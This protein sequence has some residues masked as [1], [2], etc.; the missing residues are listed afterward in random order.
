MKKL[1]KKIRFAAVHLFKGGAPLGNALV[2]ITENF[3]GKDLAT[4][5]PKNTD[6]AKIA[7]KALGIVVMLY[8]VKDGYIDVDV[9]VKFI[10]GLY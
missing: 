1:F 9:F 2:N 5:E 7:F 3:T 4:G 8:L 6:W 10:K